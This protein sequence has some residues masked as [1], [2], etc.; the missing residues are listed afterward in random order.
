[1]QEKDTGLKW[2]HEEVERV[3]GLFEHK[4]QRLAAKAAD[5]EAAAADAS[6]AASCAEH[7]C[8]E[9]EGRLAT[10]SS[11]HE[12]RRPHAARF[13]FAWLPRGTC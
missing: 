2:V 6:A 13:R 5:A 12:A 7:R 4:E 1:M 9:L 3:K 8:K 10:V 11:A